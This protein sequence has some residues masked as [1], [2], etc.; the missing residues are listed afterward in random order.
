MKEVREGGRDKGR[1][2]CHFSFSPLP[3]RFIP[4]PGSRSVEEEE[5]E[6]EKGA[7]VR[8]D[9]LL[10]LLVCDCVC[11]WRPETAEEVCIYAEISLSN[12]CACVVSILPPTSVTQHNA[13]S[14]KY[15]IGYKSSSCFFH[16]SQI[17]TLGPNKK[18]AS[19][20]NR[21][22]FPFYSAHSFSSNYSYCSVLLY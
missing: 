5:E 21:L 9:G 22:S 15:K 1:Y 4:A 6:E 12:I 8:R 16:P 11:V 10:L 17:D 18:S 19:F 7:A 2:C 20:T 14:T 3:H 13:F